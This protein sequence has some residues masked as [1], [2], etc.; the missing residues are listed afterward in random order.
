MKSFMISMILLFS[1]ILYV[2]INCF[3][4]CGI[5]DNI[6]ELIDSGNT[7]EAVSLWKEKRGYI[8]I[9][10]RDTEIDRID[11]FSIIFGE[12]QTLNNED[13]ETKR[14]EFKSAVEELKNS[15]RPNFGNIF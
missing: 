10:T 9:F 11:G 14:L 1:V 8:S 12:N 7:K 15:E 5:C 3:M 4:I 6:T 13:T 2:I